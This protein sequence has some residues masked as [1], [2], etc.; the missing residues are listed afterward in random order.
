MAIVFSVP[1]G[2]EKQR[3]CDTSLIDL[4][5]IMGTIAVSATL[6]RLDM[7]PGVPAER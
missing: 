1:C 7:L 5:N 2:A 3:A 4:L 6:T